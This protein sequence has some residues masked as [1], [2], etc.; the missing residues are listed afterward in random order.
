MYEKLLM[1]IEREEIEIISMPLSENIKGLY[2]DNVIAINN[3]VST[4]VEKTCILAE[5]LGHYHTTTGDIL[6]QA[7]ITNRKQELRARRWAVKKLI[8]MKG[9]VAAYEA[10]VRNRHELSEYLG[11]TEEFINTALEHFRGIYGYSHSVGEYTIIFN[12]LVVVKRVE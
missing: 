3:S 8:S 5:E 4:T 1:E 2:A 10:G 6:N 9:I 12:P 11:V 7:K